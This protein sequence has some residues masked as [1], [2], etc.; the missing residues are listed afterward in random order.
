M[1]REEIDVQLP[2]RLR[3]AREFGAPSEND[4]YL[5]I[6]EEAVTVAR[7]NSLSQILA[8]VKGSTPPSPPPVLRRLA[9]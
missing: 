5:Q 1:T 7:A 9:F 2:Q 4:D 8:A 6:R 3:E